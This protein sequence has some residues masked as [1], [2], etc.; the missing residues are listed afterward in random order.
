MLEQPRGYFPDFCF[1]IPHVPFQGSPGP[2]V[3]GGW[4]P[5][6]FHRDDL[7][8]GLEDP[9]PPSKKKS[10]DSLISMFPKPY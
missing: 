1:G 2:P 8:G 7:H 4:I 3:R 6:C 10:L 5:I 9:N